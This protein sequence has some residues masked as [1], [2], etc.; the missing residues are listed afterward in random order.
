MKLKKVMAMIMCAVLV[1]I[2]GVYATWNYATK[3]VATKTVAFG[4]PTLTDAT[5]SDSI[6]TLTV[7]SS[8]LKIEIDD[9]NND[10]VG[11]LVITGS[12]TITFQPHAD[13]APDIKNNGIALK[14]TIK[15][16]N[17][18]QYNSSPVFTF[19][20]ITGTTEKGLTAVIDAETIKSAISLNNISLPT[21]KEYQD[22]QAAISGTVL[23]I[24]L[25]AADAA[26]A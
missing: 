19:T 22:F 6:G 5:I 2:G 13:A 18:P 10:K 15:G 21:Y 17:N 24:T 20:E 12:I 16:G 14:Y 9:T 8:N 3:A 4:I 11:E 23:S 26:G 1:T 7:N 25:E